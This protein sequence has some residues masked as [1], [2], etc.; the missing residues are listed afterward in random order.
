MYVLRCELVAVLFYMYYCIMEKSKQS[1]F[2][3]QQHS[4]SPGDLNNLHLEE[5]NKH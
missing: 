1:Q 4:P 2:Y 5:A 3:T